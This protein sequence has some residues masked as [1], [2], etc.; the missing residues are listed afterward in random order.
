MI[1]MWCILERQWVRDQ[2]EGKGNGAQ[3]SRDRHKPLHL[4]SRTMR[5]SKAHH[6]SCIHG[7]PQLALYVDIQEICTSLAKMLQGINKEVQW[8]CFSNYFA[9]TI[10][11]QL[12]S[13]QPQRQKVQKCS[14]RWKK[15]N[16]P[17]ISIPPCPCR[18]KRSW[19]LSPAII[20]P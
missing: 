11:L 12:S 8:I 19:R 10:R 4:L 6:G 13:L 2:G 1:M 15:K 7:C 18:C 14:K 16:C 3:R 20:E 5:V 17:S 9:H